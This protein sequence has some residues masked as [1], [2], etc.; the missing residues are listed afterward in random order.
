M[1]ISR[2]AWSSGYC[3]DYEQGVVSNKFYNLE[4]YL[5]INEKNVRLLCLNYDATHLTQNYE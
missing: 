3:T 4:M 2:C 5:I 1:C